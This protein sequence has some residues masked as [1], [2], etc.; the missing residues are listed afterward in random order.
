[1]GLSRQQLEQFDFHVDQLEREHG[2]TLGATDRRHL[3]EASLEQGFTPAATEQIVAN[4]AG[5]DTDTGAQADTGD[6]DWDDDDSIAGA[7]HDDEEQELDPGTQ[8]LMHDAATDLDRMAI[9]RGRPMTREE[10]EVAAYVAH[11]QASRGQPLD[12]EAGVAAYY[13]D[14]GKTRPDTDSTAG[15][16]EFYRQRL[17]EL[18]PPAERDPDREY[19]LDN[20]KDRHDYMAARLDGEEFTDAPAGDDGGEW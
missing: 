17:A 18:D 14:T 12:L 2:I 13:E 15:R 5:H 9:R 1:M 4:L 7:D 19:D 3:L 11:E 10:R 16:A 6:D 8:R 20:Q